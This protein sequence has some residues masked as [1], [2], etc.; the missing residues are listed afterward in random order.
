MYK[1]EENLPL[2]NGVSMSVGHETR[3]FI[4][5]HAAGKVSIE[6][7][8]GYSTMFF[9][10][11]SKHHTVCFMVP[12]VEQE[13]RKYAKKIDLPLDNVTFVVGK[14]QYTLPSVKER[15]DFALI[16]GDHMYPSPMIDFYYINQLMNVGGMFV[17]DDMQIPAVRSLYDFMIVS[18]YWKLISVM[19]DGRAC[20]F[21]KTED[22]KHD[23]WGNQ[24]YN[25]K[26]LKKL[27]MVQITNL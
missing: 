5:E 6:T 13:L 3:M 12:S 18:R 14:S 27:K 8:I 21:Q 2:E 17:I 11:S 15:V 10:M 24:E 19:D 26:T 4:K 25:L 1:L 20:T 22:D 23:W 9:A 7:G 16:D